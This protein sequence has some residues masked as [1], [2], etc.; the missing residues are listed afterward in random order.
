ML[1]RID[2][3][4]FKCFEELS[5]PLAPLTLMSGSNASGKSTVLQALTLLH[6][7]IREHEWSQRLMLYGSTINLGTVADVINQDSGRDKFEITLHDSKDEENEDTDWFR[8]EFQG[9]RDDLSMSVNRV[10]GQAEGHSWDDDD[11]LLQLLLPGFPDYHVMGLT[12]RLLD[13][14]YLTAE[15]L[16]PREIYQFD[17]PQMTPV[18][19]PR[20]EHAVSI[21][22]SNGGKDILPGLA[23]DGS[24][25]KLAR[26]VDAWM[27]DF[28]PGC[29]LGTHR[30]AGTN[31]ITLGIRTSDDTDFHRPTNTGFGLTQVLPILVAALFARKEGLLLIENPEVHLHPAAQSK[32]GQFLAQAASAGVQMLIETHSDHILN[33][34]RRA[35][36]DETLPCDDVSLFYFKSRLEADEQGL[37]QVSSLIMDPKGNI[38]NWPSGFF[39]QFDK[40][41]NYFVDW[42]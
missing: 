15:R 42:E 25:P 29:V 22:S 20:G 10:S 26:Q 9:E 33:G 4:H 7:T 3:K 24:P 23:R 5:L 14:A 37:E 38:D 21:L 39:D 30:V 28:F 34:I 18:V 35:V 6:Q 32:M 1:T 16:G 19:G 40:D 36:K 8:W 27:A 2:L 13:L 11:P 12:N 41:M 31:N 17:D